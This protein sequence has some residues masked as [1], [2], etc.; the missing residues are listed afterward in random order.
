MKTGI[1]TNNQVKYQRI[2]KVSVRTKWVWW[3]TPFPAL[4]RQRENNLCLRPTLST[5]WVPEQLRMHREIFSWRNKEE[6]EEKEE[7]EEKEEKQQKQEQQHKI[8]QTKESK[9]PMRPGTPGLQLQPSKR[10]SEFSVQS[11][12]WNCR[13]FCPLAQFFHTTEKVSE[14]CFQFLKLIWARV[15]AQGTS[16]LATNPEALSSISRTYMVEAEN[17]LPQLVLWSSRAYTHTHK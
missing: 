11:I 3:H 5:N 7:R 16:V 12:L 17:Q 8:N 9:D 10:Q 1:V 2:L 15:M 6:E 13:G 14:I 4:G